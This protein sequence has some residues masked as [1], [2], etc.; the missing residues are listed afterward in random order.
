MSTLTFD[1]GRDRYEIVRDVPYNA[2]PYDDIPMMY[3]RVNDAFI[4]VPKDDML[5]LC[6]VLLVENG[7]TLIPRKES[8]R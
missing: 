6:R 1:L 8:K 5:A 7:Y 2:E 4:F 3:L